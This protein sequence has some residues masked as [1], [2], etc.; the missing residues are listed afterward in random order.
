MMQWRNKIKLA[1]AVTIKTKKFA[2]AQYLQ[3]LPPGKHGSAVQDGA[4]WCSAPLLH[5]DWSG[6]LWGSQCSSTPPNRQ[7]KLKYKLKLLIQD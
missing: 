6:Q 7:H 4:D 1:S 5:C 2:I 3:S